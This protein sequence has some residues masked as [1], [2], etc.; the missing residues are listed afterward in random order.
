M[1]LVHFTKKSLQ[2]FKA[3]Y[4]EYFQETLTDEE[5]LQRAMYLLE[6]YRVIYGMPTIGEKFFDNQIEK[7][8]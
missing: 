8:D 1:R 2:K 3:L 5:A 6:L 4:V 7:E